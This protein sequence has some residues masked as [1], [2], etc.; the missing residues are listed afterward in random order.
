MRRWRLGTFL[1]WPQLRLEATTQRAHCFINQ[2]IRLRR[3]PKNLPHIQK[4][5]KTRGK[6]REKTYNTGYLLIVTH[7]TTNLAFSNLFSPI[8]PHALA[9]P[10]VGRKRLFMEFA[11]S[12]WPLL[13][14]RGHIRGLVPMEPPTRGGCAASSIDGRHKGCLDVCDFQAMLMSAVL[15]PC[16]TC[17]SIS[18][19]L[20]TWMRC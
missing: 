6:K 20:R 19:L 15:E 1:C 3:F 4:R 7:L 2:Y 16:T 11:A 13:W 9:R 10:H 12:D 14:L 18:K 5:R 17:R 8:S